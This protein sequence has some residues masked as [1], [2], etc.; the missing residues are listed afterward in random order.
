MAFTTQLVPGGRRIGSSTDAQIQLLAGR[1][2]GTLAGATAARPRIEWDDDDVV[3]RIIKAAASPQGMSW[4]WTLAFKYYE[5][6]TSTHGYAAT[7]E[8]AN[9]RVS[10]NFF[11]EQ[12]I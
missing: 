2:N 6:R 3:G 5:D 11:E 9:K 7:R 4:L 10:G 1:V 12:G 8:A